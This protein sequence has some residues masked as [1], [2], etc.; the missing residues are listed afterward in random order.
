MLSI[1]TP[2]EKPPETEREPQRGF[3]FAITERESVRGLKS[4]YACYYFLSQRLQMY[5]PITVPIAVPTADETTPTAS[6]VEMLS[7]ANTSSRMDYAF[8]RVSS[9]G[10][11]ISENFQTF[12]GKE[13][14]RA[15]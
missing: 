7:T 8:M 4:G 5:T 14:P 9:I 13:K 11:I 15:V 6:I 10:G 1:V 2:N 12:N 3:S